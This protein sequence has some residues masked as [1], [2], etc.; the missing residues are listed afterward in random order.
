MFAQLQVLL[1]QVVGTIIH[2]G[3]MD[4]ETSPTPMA[5]GDNSASAGLEGKETS[6]EGRVG[7]RVLL[8]LLH[9]QEPTVPTGTATWL[10][11][12][13]PGAPLS[14][15]ISSRALEP[16]IPLLVLPERDRS[17]VMDQR[18]TSSPARE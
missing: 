10:F 15:I 6:S 16:T 3:P 18:M 1:G 8:E 4:P 17:R 7:I 2:S 12:G 14:S 13:G 9:I 5:T 11:M